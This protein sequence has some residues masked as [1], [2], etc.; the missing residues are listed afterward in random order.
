MAT[1][2]KFNVFVQNLAN[3]VHDFATD[4]L[5]VVLTNTLP[6]AANALLSDITDLST[7]GG[8]TAGGTNVTT[9]SSTQTSG[10]EKLIVAD[11]TFTATTGFG[12]FRYA[13]LF[14]KTPTSPL[15][16]LIVWFDYGSSISLGAG[17]TFLVDFDQT[18][19]LFTIA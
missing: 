12:P 9:T 1:Y 16:P 14:D 8:Y 18:N 15:K 3:G 7:G 6:T 13:V 5:A 10:T 19:G 2:N 4:Q 11:L 17:E